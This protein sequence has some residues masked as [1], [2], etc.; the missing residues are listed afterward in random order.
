M[1]TPNSFEFHVEYAKAIVSNCGPDPNQYESHLDWYTKLNEQMK[2]G[3]ITTEQ[4]NKLS[5]IFGTAYSSETMQGHAHVKPLGYAGDFQ[6][7]EKI[8]DS[9]IS[10]DQRLRKYDLFF[11]EQHAA[12]AVRN[13]KKYFQTLVRNIC[14]RETDTVTVLNL[15]SGP[16]REIR[17]LFDETP[18]LPVRFLNVDI[19]ERAIAYAKEVLGE[20]V[21][22][23]EFVQQNIFRFRPKE[24]YSLIW[25]AGLFD[26]FDDRTFYRILSRF[27]DSLEPDGELV[28]GNFGI[29]N[30]TKGYMEA[31]ATRYLHHRSDGQLVELAKLAGAKLERHRVR[32]GFE[33]TRV[34]RFLHIMQAKKTIRWDMPHGI[35][36][37]KSVEIPTVKSAIDPNDQENDWL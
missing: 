12:I 16:C 35:A 2:S 24:K 28:I 37:P 29:D 14:E 17:E 10:P 9:W 30:P 8:Y 15:A 1:N 18:D 25:S 13:R 34:N 21:D 3:Q 32:I 23:T 6:I 33:S 22:K 4:R 31:L 19:D 20:H 5:A 36:G 7:I 26:Y 11:H 27:V